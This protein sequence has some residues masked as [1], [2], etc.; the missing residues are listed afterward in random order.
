MLPLSTMLL[1]PL[2]SLLAA[3][4]FA[5]SGFGS[6]LVSI[7]LL[8]LLL[9]LKVVVPLV[10]LLDF[11]ASLVMGLRLRGEIDRPEVMRVLPAMFVGIAVGVTLLVVLPVRGMLMTLGVMVLCYGVFTLAR[12]GAP[13][14]LS[15]G[16]AVPAGLVGG[17]IGGAMGVGGPVY[18]MYYSGRIEDP[19]RL[20]ASMSLTF[21]LSTSAR[22]ALLA[23]TGLLLDRQLWL[24]FALQLPA[25]LAGLYLGQ[26]IGR[27]LS[28]SQ[29]MRAVALLLVA[30]GVSV[31]WKAA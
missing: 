6:A 27:G 9:P 31:L 4:V 5:I 28:R 18:V 25:V 24:A 21:V 7:P 26:H 20:R 2:V 22:I 17:L 8:A 3:T 13:L 10:V 30:S 19:T 14:K 29:V 23:A 1:A 15:R 11:C 16:W 12:G